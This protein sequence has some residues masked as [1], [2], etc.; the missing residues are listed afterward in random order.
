[1]NEIVLRIIYEAIDELNEKLNCDQ[2]IIKNL[3]TKLCGAGVHLDS[4]E[5]INLIE[6]VECKIEEFYQQQILLVDD[7]TLKMTLNPFSTIFTFA[8]FVE[9]V[10][11]NKV[12]R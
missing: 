5:L 9:S 7:R 11:K 2:K 8:E 4:I 3:N 12:K 6:L 10:L 1:M